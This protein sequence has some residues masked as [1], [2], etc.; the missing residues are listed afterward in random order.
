MEKGW[1]L[2]FFQQQDLNPQTH[3]KPK[4]CFSTIVQLQM[5]TPKSQSLFKF[6]NDLPVWEAKNS[7][8]G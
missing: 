5:V 2:G 4:D 6:Y 8:V 3:P 7:Q 1:S